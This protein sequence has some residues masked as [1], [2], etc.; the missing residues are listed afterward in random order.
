MEN[1]DLILKIGLGCVLHL[2]ILYGFLKVMGL[3][4]AWFGHRDDLASGKHTQLGV[5]DAL[6]GGVLGGFVY[7]RM[8]TSEG[9]EEMGWDYDYAVLG[10]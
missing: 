4:D 10:T 6:G 9:R 5:G 3:W 2:A 8:G 7:G 1:W